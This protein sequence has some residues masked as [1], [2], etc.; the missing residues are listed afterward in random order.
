[1]NFLNPLFL[2]LLAAAAIPLVIHL[3]SRRKVREVRFSTL[4]FLAGSDRRSMRRISLRRL[5]LLALRMAAI[6]LV[7]LAFARPVITGGPAALFPGG[8]PRAACVLLDRSYSMGVGGGG[9]TVFER[10]KK[11]VERIASVLGEEDEVTI[12]L[13]DSRSEKLYEGRRFTPGPALDLLGDIEPSYYGTDL[14]GAVDDA[15]TILRSSR[16]GAKELY[17]VSDFQRGGSGGGGAERHDFAV[18][19]FLMPIHPEPGPNVAVSSVLTPRVAVHRSETARLVVTLVNHS[20]DMAAKFPVRVVLE[21]TVVIE[22]EIDLGPGAARTERIDIPMERAGWIKGEVSKREDRL[23]ADDRR[24]FCILAREK[25][26]VLLLSGADSFWLEQALSPE[27]TEGDISLRSRG[28]GELVTGDLD[29]ADA[30]VLGTGPGPREADIGLLEG[31]VE[32]GGRILAFVTEGAEERVWRLSGKKARVSFGKENGAWGSL[33]PGAEAPSFLSPFGREDL[34]SL[35]RVRFARVP[36]I[37][38]VPPEERL[39]SYRD[40]T[41]FMWKTARG[42]GLAIFAVFDPSARGG[43]FVLSPLFLPL[44]Q[45]AVTA[46]DDGAAAGEGALVGSETSRKGRS[47]ADYT[48]ILPGG[49][50]LEPEANGTVAIPAGDL[51]GFVDLL[52]GPETVFRMAVNPDCGVESDLSFMSAEEAADSLGLKN[53]AA[54]GEGDRFEPGI[55]TAREGR[56]ISTLLVVAALALLATELLIAQR[57]EMATEG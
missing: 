29:W 5:I 2:A 3:F 18:R 53:W 56:E 34:E 37:G 30:V 28:W 26:K 46:T 54:I 24:Y 7:A 45:Q 38:G 23:A 42:E 22:R 16:I 1:M 33:D 43:D 10:A 48:V 50:Q 17:I 9:G 39:M 11:Q 35:S 20:P 12:L 44:V 4:R 41:P 6:A 31:F 8:G 14:R 19:T 36:D 51:P 32:G 40:G 47:G 57:K 15:M 27:G 25:V 13:F 52:D 21:G 55:R 49:T